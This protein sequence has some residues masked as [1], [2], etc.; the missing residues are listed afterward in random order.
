MKEKTTRTLQ[1][2]DEVSMNKLCVREIHGCIVFCCKC[3]ILIHNNGS[4]LDCGHHHQKRMH[5]QISDD[6]PRRTC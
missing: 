6:L 3:L 2:L 1:V 4:Y 5:P